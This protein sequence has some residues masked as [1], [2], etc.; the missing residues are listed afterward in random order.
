MTGRCEFYA[1]AHPVDT[2]LHPTIPPGCRWAVYRADG[3]G[4]APPWSDL[5]ACLG[6]GWSPEIGAA[7]FVADQAAHIALKAAAAARHE[8]PDMQFGV[9]HV[10]LDFDPIPA[11]GDTG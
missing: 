9:R 8:P 4:G 6:A 11:E 7:G 2:E 5:S 1:L 10:L 3:D